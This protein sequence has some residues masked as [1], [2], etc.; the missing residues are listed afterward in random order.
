MSHLP[1]M[2]LDLLQCHDRSSSLTSAKHNERNADR[3]WPTSGAI[4]TEKHASDRTG[5]VTGKNDNIMVPAQDTSLLQCH[6]ETVHPS[7][8]AQ[9]NVELADSP[10]AALWSACQATV[11]VD[12]RRY[13]AHADTATEST[14]CSNQTLCWHQQ[15]QGAEK[16]Q[17]PSEENTP[18]FVQRQLPR[19]TDGLELTPTQTLESPDPPPNEPTQYTSF[20]NGQ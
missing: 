6:A 5:H 12:T 17:V 10:K 9:Q 19:W 8:D 1:A 15:V 4:V 16:E 2:K 11:C 13:R 18:H 14:H 20:D 3:Q 7:A